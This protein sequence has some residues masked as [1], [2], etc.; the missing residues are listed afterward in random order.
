MK[1]EFKGSMKIEFNEGTVAHAIISEMMSAYMV[2]PYLSRTMVLERMNH[3][4]SLDDI[5]NAETNLRRALTRS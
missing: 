4:V 1:I 2:D 3:K 5:V